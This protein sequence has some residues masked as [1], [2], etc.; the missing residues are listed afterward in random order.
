[1]SQF[2]KIYKDIKHTLE[3]HKT[4]IDIALA[5]LAL[6]AALPATEMLAE[7]ETEHGVSIDA[8]D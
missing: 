7:D 3:K 8:I 4:E 1:M 2:T 6:A 5:A